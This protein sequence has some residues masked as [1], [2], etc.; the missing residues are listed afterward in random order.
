M[1]Y[2]TDAEEIKNIIVD[3]AETNML[4]LDTEIADYKTKKPRLSLIQALAYPHD[5]TGQRT[6]IF[7]VLD[8]PNLSDFFIEHIMKNEQITKVF[9]NAKSDV[10]FLGKKEAKNIVC[11]FELA[12]KIPYHLLPVKKYSLKVL[13]E[14][15]TDFQQI[16]KEEQGSDWGI[17]PLTDLQLQYARMDC[18]YL[19]Q[20]YLKLIPL[21]KQIQFEPSQ[22]NIEQ[23][24]HRHQEI[25]AQCLSLQ[26]EIDFLETRIKEAMVVQNQWENEKFK[27]NNVE[28]KTIKANIN[29]LLELVDRHNLQL[30][31]QV[32]L[33]KDVQSQLGDYLND[34]NVETQVKNYYQ[35]KSK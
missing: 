29:H 20:V 24:L 6:Y 15:L 1:V 10:R 30:D 11:T 31:Y 25:E 2:L 26:S 19:A 9:H 14:Y 8:K 13:T 18:V 23:L 12:K 28:R 22:E 16:S 35:L 4:W 21:E 27:L 32:T 5:L 3:L 34:L 33:T 17:R 7:D